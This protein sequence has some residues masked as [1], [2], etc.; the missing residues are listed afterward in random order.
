MGVAVLVVVPDVE[1][2]VVAG[3]DGGQAVHHRRV[4][5]AEQIGGD[6]LRGVDVVDLLTQVGVGGHAA[7]EV[8]HLVLL[9]VLF[10]V[11]VQHGHGHV[12]GGH[13]DG[14][15][16]ELALELRK[17]LGH[18]LGGTGLGEHHVQT[19]GAAAAVALVEVV[20]QVLVVGVGVDGLDVAVLD[21]VAVVDHLQHRGDAVGGAGRGG[22]DALVA[23][24]VLVDA[25]DDVRDV[26]LAR[27]GEQHAVHALGLEVLGQAL[28]VAPRTGVVHHDGVVD[29]VGG[30]VDLCRVVGVDHL[31]GGAVGPDD[32]LFLVHGDGAVERA[33]HGIAAQQRGALD[34]VDVALLAH[35]HRAQAHAA[36][37]RLAGDQDAGEQAADAAEAVEHDVAGLEFGGGADDVG[38]LAVEEGT[39]VLLV[40]VLELLGQAAEVD[41]RG[42]EVHLH[43]FA[44]DRQRLVERE[45]L[46]VDAAGVAVRLNDVDVGDTHQQAAV[47]RRHRVV[48]AVQAADQRQHL[49]REGELVVPFVAGVGRFGQRRSFCMWESGAIFLPV[50]APLL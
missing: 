2:E 10:Q 5:G 36:V 44:Q 18:G 22:Q 42:A 41:R 13:A 47:D 45:F 16:G 6:D 50:I 46:L 17:R 48:L 27:R 21:T 11:Q 25:V 3:G 34:D 7:Q 40:G 20:R 49:L 29:A 4:G 24:H 26:A 39:Q 1:H 8:V 30:V 37:H 14:V 33:V 38:E 12:R 35:H 19:G 28:A 9:H 15:A 23:D 43:E 31:D 32:F